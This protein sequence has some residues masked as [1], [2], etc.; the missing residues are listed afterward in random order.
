MLLPQI[1][2]GL[3]KEKP[4]V[5]KYDPVNLQ[6]SQAD[7]IGANLANF[8][9]AS[10]L[11]SQTNAFNQE[12]LLKSLRKMIPNFDE[13]M[14]K[15]ASIVGSQ[16]K[17][18][19]PTDVGKAISSNAAARALGGG[20]AGSGLHGNLVARDLGLTSLDLMQRG[21]DSADRWLKTSKFMTDSGRMDASSMFINPLQMWQSQMENNKN[22]FNRDWVGNQLDAEYSLGTTVG[23]A[24]IKTDDQIMQIISSIA[25]S[26]GGAMMG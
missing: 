13:I 11:A 18:E 21:L 10:Q 4:K 24:M 23:N 12:E 20:Y 16:L 25:G 17:G 9:S 5:P 3:L 8:A 19:I 14:G 1:I 15:T 2:G 6:D 26:A 22:Q 7:A